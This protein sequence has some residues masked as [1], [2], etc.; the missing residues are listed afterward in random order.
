MLLC[1]GAIHFKSYTYTEE[2]FIEMTTEKKKEEVEKKKA[3]T[4]KLSNHKGKIT[5][6]TYND[7]IKS[8]LTEEDNHQTLKEFLAKMDKKYSK[9]L[10]DNQ[11]AENLK[12]AEET[13]K[14]T[15][16][17]I[18]NSKDK[19]ISVQNRNTEKMTTVTY[20]LENRIVI[21]EIPNPIYTCIAGGVVVITIKVNGNGDVIAA[22]QDTETSNTKDGCLVE[23]AIT[24]ARS[25]KF[26][27]NPQNK[28]QVGTIT[29]V[30]Q[31]K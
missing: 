11:T 17:A 6:K 28:S 19:N 25:T 20:S 9:P 5:H 24:Y 31:S 27:A 4:K 12:K 15:R 2:H 10:A 7:K 23:N 18:K 29:Y 1:V 13:I 22:K 30:F 14:N 16:E 21:G 3:T 26:N 8:E